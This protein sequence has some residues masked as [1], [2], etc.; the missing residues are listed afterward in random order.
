[1]FGVKIDYCREFNILGMTLNTLAAHAN[2][3]KCDKFSLA[4]NWFGNHDSSF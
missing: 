2:K 3:V 1:M 4:Y